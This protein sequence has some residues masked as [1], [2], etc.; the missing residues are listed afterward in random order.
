L[1]SDGGRFY[2]SCDSSQSIIVYDK[3]A[4]IVKEAMASGDSVGE[5]VL[6]KKYLTKEELKE[7]LKPEYMIRPRYRFQ[8]RTVFDTVVK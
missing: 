1:P 7:I 2:W 6:K 5:I 8:N 4:T 3:S